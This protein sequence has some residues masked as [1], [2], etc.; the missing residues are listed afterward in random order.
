MREHEIALDW[1]PFCRR[2]HGRGRG[3][4]CWRQGG[5]AAREDPSHIFADI[6]RIIIYVEYIFFWGEDEGLFQGCFIFFLWSL[7]RGP[8]VVTLVS[9]VFSLS[10]YLS[11]FL[12]YC[13]RFLLLFLSRYIPS[14]L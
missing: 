10:L 12:P 9:R 5:V 11:C 14:R 8:L 4:W 1:D 7:Y 2:C 6:L 13:M 3:R